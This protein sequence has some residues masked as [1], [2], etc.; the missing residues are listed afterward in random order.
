MKNLLDALPFDG[1][2]TY[3]IGV[4]SILIGAGGIALRF[5]GREEYSLSIEEGRDLILYGFGLLA[6][7]HK[8]DK[9]L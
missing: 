4:A 1:Y 6:L 7:G 9:V 5:A 2:K 8:V 3:I